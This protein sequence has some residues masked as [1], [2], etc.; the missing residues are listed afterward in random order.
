MRLYEPFRKSDARKR[1]AKAIFY[2]AL[3][4]LGAAA[5]MLLALAAYA[6]FYFALMP[7]GAL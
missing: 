5:A 6:L 4:I 2:G 3:S 7:K 1:R